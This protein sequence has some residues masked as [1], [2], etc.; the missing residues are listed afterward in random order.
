MERPPGGYVAS[1]AVQME[2]EQELVRGLV[3]GYDAGFPI[4]GELERYGVIRGRRFVSLADE[5]AAYL[6][7]EALGGERQGDRRVTIEGGHGI[8]V[9]V[10]AVRR[11]AARLPKYFSVDYA[12]QGRDFHTLALVVFDS[13]WSVYDSYMILRADLGR[14]VVP[15]K[16]RRGHRLPIGRGWRSDPAVLPLRLT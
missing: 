11:T 13:D 9:Q 14:M 2:T 15:G 3:R 4:A 12:D 1:M 16:K 6:V 7:A 8:T 10:S 5:Y